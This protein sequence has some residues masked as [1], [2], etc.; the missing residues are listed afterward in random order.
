MSSVEQILINIKSKKREIF[1]V[2]SVVLVGLLG[3]GLGR[4]S[5]IDEG[6]EPVIIKSMAASSAVGLSSNLVNGGKFVASKS[7]TTYHF[8]WCPGAKKISEENKVWFASAAIAE[9]AGYKKAI[10]CKGL[11]SPTF[12]E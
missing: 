6:R 7:G 12:T 9:R 2:A 8:P 11:S 3:F 4:L 1:F 5:K 10:N